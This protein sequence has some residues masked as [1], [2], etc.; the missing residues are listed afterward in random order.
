MGKRHPIA[1]L[2]RFSVYL[3]GTGSG[4]HASHGDEQPF[5]PWVSV[6]IVG[7]EEFFVTA[8]SAEQKHG[9]DVVFGVVVVLRWGP[10]ADD[11][12]HGKGFPFL[13]EPLPVGLQQFAGGTVSVSH[14]PELDEARVG[15]LFRHALPSAGGVADVEWVVVSDSSCR[16]H[17]KIKGKGYGLMVKGHTPMQEVTPK[18]VAMAVSTVMM[19]WSILLQVFLFSMIF[20]F[21]SF[22]LCHPDDRREEGSRVHPLVSIT[23]C[24]RDPSLHFVPLWMTIT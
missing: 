9:A 21:S 10:P 2:Y 3:V 20:D 23:I 17:C 19:M 13:P 14:A 7:R 8:Q 24:F 18:V 6:G 11:G 16:V 22:L 5:Q 12:P 15:L 1:F 4:L